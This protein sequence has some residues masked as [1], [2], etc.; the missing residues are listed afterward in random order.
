MR[1]MRHDEPCQRQSLLALRR[2]ARQAGP[3]ADDACAG[4]HVALDNTGFGFERYD[5]FGRYRA[6]ENGFDVDESGA[7][8]ESCDS[9][10]D[11]EFTGVAELAAR[12]AASPLTRDCLATQWYR[13][14]MGRVEDSTDTCSLQQVKSRFSAGQG[15]FRELLVGIVLSDAFRYRPAMEAQ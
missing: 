11:G 1:F 12:I 7:M 8:I 9:G 4:C 3:G 5:Q 2:T 6:T 10:L 13:Y 15:S 14:A